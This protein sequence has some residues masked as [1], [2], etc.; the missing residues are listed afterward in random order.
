MPD[1]KSKCKKKCINLCSA[2]M[3]C[4]KKKI[5]EQEKLN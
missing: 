3:Y 5:V 2:E 1:G 4:V